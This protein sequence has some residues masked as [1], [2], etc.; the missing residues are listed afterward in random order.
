MA[1]RWISIAS[2]ILVVAAVG[3]VRLVTI[4]DIRVVVIVD[5]RSLG[6][7]TLA[8][9]IDLIWSGVRGQV[10]LVRL[11]GAFLAAEKPGEEA[12]LLV[13]IAVARSVVILRAGAKPL[14][15]VVVAG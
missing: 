5:G 4:V 7:V 2:L 15:L 9:V 12:A 1:G 14:R 11:D 13:G 6:G 3:S 10:I 8:G